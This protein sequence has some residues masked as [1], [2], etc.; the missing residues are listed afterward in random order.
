MKDELDP[1][2]LRDD[3]GRLQPAW[4][5]TLASFVGLTLGPSTILVFCFGSFV[6]PL[7]KEFGWG[8]GAISLGGTL[9][10]VMVVVTALLA[11]WM[12][13]RFGAR[14]LVLTSIPLFGAGVGALAFLPANIAMFYAGLALV[15]LLGI[16]IWPV[17]YNKLAAGW[18]DR[19]LGL[20]LGI[21]NAGVGVGA[22]LLPM[23]VAYVIAAHGWRAAYAVLGVLAIAIPWPVAA[24]LLRERRRYP[25]LPSLVE[26][27]LEGLTL[28]QATGTRV[29]WL[30]AAGFAIL[31]AAS[32]AIV[33]HQVRILV[34]AG[35]AVGQAGAMQSVLGLS[36]IVGRVGT[37]WLLDHV[38]VP[39][40]MAVLCIVAAAALALYAL[41]LPYNTAAACAILAGLLIGAEYDVLAFSVARYF[42]RQSFGAI[43]A[44][45]LASMQISGAAAVAAVG[46]MRSS[47]GGYSSS[48]AALAAS[49]M[50]ASFLFAR[51]GPYRSM[52]T[53]ARL[54][55]R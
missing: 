47:S 7:E 25:S 19:R 1:E 30:S 38:K 18:F 22:A 37:G 23:L 24:L 3:S 52:V 2:N 49:L 13:D 53:G 26:T 43:Y 44:V 41:G 12:I 10:G 4:A 32:G 54:A 15:S 39:V 45:L 9:I 17:S 27:R 20:S 29:F 34:D 31:G 16:G 36:L 28:G 48:L 46:Y 55:G 6:S 40:L 8:V 51:L 35:M 5:A 11:G 33:F 50:L 21:V 14:V 42:G